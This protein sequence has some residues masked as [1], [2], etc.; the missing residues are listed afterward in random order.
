MSMNYTNWLRG[1]SLTASVLLLAA[2][3]KAPR[4]LDSV[5]HEQVDFSGSWELDYQASDD[6]YEKI[7]MLQRMA[8][9]RAQRMPPPQMGRR[10]PVIMVNSRPVNSVSSI[11]GLGQMAELISK[12][13]LLEIEQTNS[14]IEI[15]RKD[16]FPLSCSF[17]GGAA[18]PIEDA[19]GTELCGWDYHQLI[20]QI[21]LPDG[22]L[23]QHRITMAPA[24]DKLNIAT[25]VQSRDLP[26]PFTLNRVYQRFTP[27]PSEFECE[28]TV[29]KG[30]SCRRVSS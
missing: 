2:C 18:V 17:H 20:F 24:G 10:G 14:A 7:E 4:L 8:A 9:Y 28:T 25:T 22:F 3:A 6:L 23:I 30:K 27:L 11:I 1:A 21:D 29:S 13:T 12:T 19:L 26:E 15:S 5:S 16:D